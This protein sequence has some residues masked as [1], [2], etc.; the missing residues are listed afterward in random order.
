MPTELN[1][2]PIASA[3][4]DEMVLIFSRRWGAILATY[5]SDF[6]AW[7]SRMQCPAVLNEDD[8]GLITHWMPLPA[9]PDPAER[10]GTPA[11]LP[12][13]LTRLVESASAREAA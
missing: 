12:A 13:S 4:R 11:S 6:K 10:G 1:W 2:Q 8:I 3:P 9:T 7:F 5:R